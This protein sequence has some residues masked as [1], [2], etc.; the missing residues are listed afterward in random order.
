MTATI[1]NMD[2]KKVDVFSV[3]I[4]MPDDLIGIDGMV[5]EV[6]EINSLKDGYA[7]SYVDEYGELEVIE[8]SDD[9]KFD[10][11]VYIED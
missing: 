3:D 5:C 4:L 9:A 6:K 10:F 1:L 11:Y 2:L 7:I 8:V